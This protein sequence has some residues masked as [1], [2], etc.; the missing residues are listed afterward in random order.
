MLVMHAEV[1]RALSGDLHFL[2]DVTAPAG[3]NK[4]GAHQAPSLSD[5]WLR[6]V[7]DLRISCSILP[8]S[9]SVSS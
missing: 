4:A 3:E 9:A 2:R 5:S 7:A 6:L 1:E 8:R